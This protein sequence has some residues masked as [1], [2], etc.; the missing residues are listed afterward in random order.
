MHEMTRRNFLK[1][2]GTAFAASSLA[3]LA[4]P[5][6]GFAVEAET[7]E[8]RIKDATESTAICCFCSLGCGGIA[9][10]EGGVLVAF[11]GDPDSP[12]N[13]GGLCSKGAAQINLVNVYDPE[14][15]ELQLNPKR[16]TGPKYRAPG[17]SEWQD[18]SWEDAIARIAAKVKETRDASFEALSGG[19]VVN[20][21]EAIAHL[22][23][24]ALPNEVLGPLQKLQRALGLVHIEHQARL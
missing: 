17:A 15:G 3:G 22:G 7:Y 10:V 11:E 18:I 24:G 21:T 9:S 23:C 5:R 19:T 1:V 12:I 6:A 16:I 8:F 13:R 4:K 2:L 20:R 14:T